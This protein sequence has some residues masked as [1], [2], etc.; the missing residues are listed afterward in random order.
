MQNID[1]KNYDNYPNDTCVNNTGLNTYYKQTLYMLSF[2]FS[3]ICT[4]IKILQI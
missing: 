2:G 4:V 1:K 3:N